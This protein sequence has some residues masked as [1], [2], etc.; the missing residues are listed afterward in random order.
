MWV[1]VRFEV[2]H[3]V[4][5][6]YRLDTTTQNIY[7]VEVF[8]NSKR[9]LMA[10]NSRISNVKRDRQSS[11]AVLFAGTRWRWDEMKRRIA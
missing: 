6:K 4:R 3:Y 7:Q 8:D 5:V 10:Y 9:R 11:G 2:I 1:I